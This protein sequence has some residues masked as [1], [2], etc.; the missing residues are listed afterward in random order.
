MSQEVSK[1]IF[2]HECNRCDFKWTS[3]AASPGS[4]ANQKCRSPYWDKK[5]VR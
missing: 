3:K 4:C 1:G 5:R 2:L